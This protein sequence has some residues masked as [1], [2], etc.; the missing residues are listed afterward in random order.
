M[1]NQYNENSSSNAPVEQQNVNATVAGGDVNNDASGSV[2]DTVVSTQAQGDYAETQNVNQ[3]DVNDFVDDDDDDLPEMAQATLTTP[4]VKVAE[5][6][7]NVD[8]SI[9]S[10]GQGK[11]SNLKNSFSNFSLESIPEETAEDLEADNLQE[12]DS[13]QSPKDDLLQAMIAE[14]ASNDKMLADMKNRLSDSAVQ[15][16]FD[17]LVS[18]YNDNAPVDDS[19]AVNTVTGEQIDEFAVQDVEAISQDQAIFDQ[20]NDAVDQFNDAAQ[21]LETPRQG[22]TPEEAAQRAREERE[23]SL[24]LDNIMDTAEKMNELDN[25]IDQFNDAAQK[26]ETPRQGD[27]PE[28]A[29]QRAIE[30]EE[31]SRELDDIIS[32][33]ENTNETTNVEAQ[34][35]ENYPNDLSDVL[36][37]MDEEIEL[38]QQELDSAVESREELIEAMKDGN[39]IDILLEGVDGGQKVDNREIETILE[40]LGELTA[41]AEQELEMTETVVEFGDKEVDAKENISNQQMDSII[42]E[43]GFEKEALSSHIDGEVKDSDNTIDNAPNVGAQQSSGVG[44]GAGA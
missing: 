27:T 17:N 43:A 16:S 2:Q 26:L 34:D 36:S 14:I 15:E 3:S 28:E 7:A 29:A 19:P 44:V 9:V 13:E 6:I 8:E 37:K 1:A 35:Q 32:E 25:A 42:Q 10:V 4:Q 18:E 33:A 41:G 24:E 39:N 38:K 5:G 22:D 11:K 30:E 21:K 40:D 31:L 20:F 12:A 23:L